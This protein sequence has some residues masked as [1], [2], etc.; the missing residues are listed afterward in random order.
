[1]DT[2]MVINSEFNSSALQ[3]LFEEMI[4]IDSPE[5]YLQST[6]I[7]NNKSVDLIKNMTKEQFVELM[8]K[9]LSIYTKTFQDTEYNLGIQIDNNILNV[10][11]L[12]TIQSA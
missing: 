11:I 9:E 6:H 10:I 7:K 1:M 4:K 8:K 3:T 12:P 5:I 2:S